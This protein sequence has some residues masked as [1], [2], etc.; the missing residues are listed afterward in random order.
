MF[1][2][3]LTHLARLDFGWFL[4]LFLNNL[5]WVF[6]MIFTMHILTDGKKTM[7]GALLFTIDVLVIFEFLTVGGF[8]SLTP[9]LMLIYYVSK[10]ALLI[11]AENSKFLGKNLLL[12][13]ALQAWTVVA[14]YT[15]FFG[16]R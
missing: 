13:S 6:L 1:L 4:S 5:A 2:E 9:T 11:F 8:S 14:G 10:M 15:L 7:T 16:A 3:S 12:L